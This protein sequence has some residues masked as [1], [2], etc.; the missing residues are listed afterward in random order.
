MSNPRVQTTFTVDST[1]YTASV[2]GMKAQMVEFGNTVKRTSHST[3]TDVQATSGALRLIDGGITNNIRS[4]ERFLASIKGVGAAVQAIYPM[5]GAIAVGAVVA[6]GIA[7]LAAFIQKTREAAAAF[8]ASFEEMSN[9]SRLSNDELERSN[10]ELEKQIDKLTGAH[11]NLLAMELIDARIEAD[12]LAMS[13]AKA[14]KEMKELLSRDSVS[15]GSLQGAARL[16]FHGDASTADTDKLINEMETARA[17]A[18]QDLSDALARGDDKAAKTA[19]D[20]LDK[21]ASTQLQALQ[22]RRTGAQKIQ[23]EG[24]V[25]GDE[26]AN[27]GHYGAEINTIRSEQDREQENQRHTADE[28]KLQQ[29][30]DAKEAA[31][32]SKQEAAKLMS[33]YR[34]EANTAKGSLTLGDD[35]DESSYRARQLAAESAFWA[36]KLEIAQNGSEAYKDIQK[37]LNKLYLESHQQAMAA[38]AER[39]KLLAARQ[40]LIRD[41]FGGD[42]QDLS[43]SPETI[44]DMRE[45]GKAANE[46]LVTMNQSI[47]LQER[48]ADNWRQVQ[49]QVGLASGAIGKYDAA[50]QLAALHQEQHARIL[51]ELDNRRKKLDQYYKPDDREKPEA[52]AAYQQLGNDQIQVAGD[53]QV[54][55]MEDQLNI[56][57]NTFK[58]A[59]EN[60]LK[61][62][63]AQSQDTA[64][65]VRE[66]WTSSIGSINEELV[67]MMSTRHNYGLTREW[68]NLGAGIFRNVA[69]TALQRA[70]GSLLNGIGGNKADGSA[71]NPLYVRIVGEGGSPAAGSLPGVVK[72]IFSGGDTQSGSAAGGFIS[73]LGKVFSGLGFAEG[74]QPP[75]G[76][77][78]LVGE[79]GPEMFVPKVAGTVIPNDQIG[80]VTHNHHWNID[81]RGAA[82][83]AAVH[84][85][86]QRGI[87]KAMPTIVSTTIRAHQ[88]ANSRLPPSRRK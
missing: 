51:D 85:A 23:R 17:G 64:A 33:Q 44:T 43:R 76:V 72:H 13:A 1:G 10:L 20:A 61:E 37:E 77:A 66:I 65:Q 25:Y 27:I 29:L 22:T 28:G 68:G 3:I 80:G 15:F 53:F 2:N 57:S 35:E 36:S 31:E 86:V 88:D 14:A 32:R 75:V 73:G 41:Q 45:G 7:E 74:G 18:A 81:A 54:Q 49:I 47:D 11:P 83:P 79:N 4:A 21:L 24:A 6:K 34:D 63:V 60:T 30:Q 5:I 12:K 87:A 52:R 71:S 48:I 82:D 46:M 56:A 16:I 58:G 70:E 38:E 9:S 67:K 84:T 42:E 39:S 19:R 8:K 62:Y 78:S 40:K 69:G 26:S 50:V 55:Q 59:W